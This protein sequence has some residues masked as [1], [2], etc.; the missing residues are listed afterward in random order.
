VSSKAERLNWLPVFG[1]KKKKC[2]LSTNSG[3]LDSSHSLWRST[4]TVEDFEDQE[5]FLDKSM[6]LLMKILVAHLRLLQ[7]KGLQLVLLLWLQ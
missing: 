7:N 2:C 1:K 3:K 5:D 4:T 6:G